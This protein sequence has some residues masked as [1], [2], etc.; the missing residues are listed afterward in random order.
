MERWIA[1]GLNS[2]VIGRNVN[3]DDYA[4]VT[5]MYVRFD[6]VGTV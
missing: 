1:G 2:R 5:L 3:N 4:F 6:N